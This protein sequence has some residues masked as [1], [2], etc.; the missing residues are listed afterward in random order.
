MWDPSRWGL[1]LKYCY[2]LYKLWYI[3]KIV[4]M[5]IV[6]NIV[7]EKSSLLGW[8]KVKTLAGMYKK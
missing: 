5:I 4:Y 3:E 6:G 2:V 7:T 1:V 8:Y